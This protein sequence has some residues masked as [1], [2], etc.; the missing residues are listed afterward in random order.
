M[1]I[2]SCG[3]RVIDESEIKSREEELYDSHFPVAG[4]EWMA[5]SRRNQFGGIGRRFW[6]EHGRVAFEIGERRVLWL[7][8]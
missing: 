8:V 1:R 5:R 4:W 2:R 3:R 7:P 6:A